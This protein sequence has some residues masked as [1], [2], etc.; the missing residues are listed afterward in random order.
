LHGDFLNLPFKLERAVV[1]VIVRNRRTEVAAHVEAFARVKAAGTVR[2]NSAWPISAPSTLSTTVPGLPGPVM[3]V[4]TVILCFASGER[5][6]ATGFV[7]FDDHH[8]VEIDE[9]AFVHVKHETTTGAAKGVED[10]AGTFATLQVHL[11]RVALA[12]KTRGGKLGHPAG[13]RDEGQV[14]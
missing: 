6:L 14:V 5:L 3:V 4:S 10:A 12:A 8:V 2:F 11:H 13:A 1:E 9:V 7:L